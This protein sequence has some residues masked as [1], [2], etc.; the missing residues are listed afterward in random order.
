MKILIFGGNGGIGF[1][2]CQILAKRHPDIELHATYRSCKPTTSPTNMTWHQVDVTN[3][4]QIESLMATFDHLDCVI[5]AIGLLHTAQS[6]PEKDLRSFS[7]DFF[8]KNMSTN[9]LPSL[10][11]AKHCQAALK[12]STHPKFATVSARVGSISDNQ[13]GGWYSYR[14]SKAALN[15]LLKTLSIEWART[16]PKACVLSLHPGTTDTPLSRPFQSN[17]PAG[18]L[19]KPDNV[20]RDLLSLIEHAQPKDSGRFLSYDGRDLPW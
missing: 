13:L 6:G 2:M 4:P 7:A 12:A 1:A 8:W 16:M 15:M 9:T 10:L 20:A 11:I 19:F 18:K 17:V 14:A 3:E 5:N